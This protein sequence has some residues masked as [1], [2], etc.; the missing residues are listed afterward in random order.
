MESFSTVM[1]VILAVVI[2]T[3]FPL[4]WTA[5]SQE[6]IAQT[7]IQT[8]VSNFVNMVATKGKITRNDYETFTQKLA[9][10][11]NTFDVEIELQILD[12]NPG[13]KVSITSPN[14]IGENI[15]YSV[16]TTTILD[17]LNSK[18]E[19]LLKKGDKIIV[20]V[21]N[22]NIT[23]ATQMKNFFYKVV[24]KNIYTIGASATQQIINNGHPL[25]PEMSH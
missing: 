23:L 16:F 9:A 15:Y 2:M 3:V 22:T 6:D 25:Q 4:M 17:K 1:V 24:G 13:K 11:G 7:S 8:L 5:K 21:K 12:D 20:N 18:D 19:Y 14:L 10:T